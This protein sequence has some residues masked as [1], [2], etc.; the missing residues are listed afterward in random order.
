ML[1]VLTNPIPVFEFF[2]DPGCYEV[3]VGVF[4]RFVIQTV[5][6]VQFAYFEGR[7]NAI[8][9]GLATDQNGDFMFTVPPSDARMWLRV[10]TTAMSFSAATVSGIDQGTTQRLAACVPFVMEIKNDPSGTQTQAA[11]H[12]GNLSLQRGYVFQGIVLDADGNPLSDVRS[13]SSGEYGPHSGPSTISQKDGRFEFAAR[14]A[15]EFTIHPDARLRNDAGKVISEDVQAV[16]V[17]QAVKS[18]KERVTELVIRAVPHTELNFNWLDKRS[19][20]SQPVAYYGGFR[21][22]GYVTAGGSR[23]YWTTRATLAPNSE[24]KLLRAKV[25]VALENA[26]L[27]L[28][29]DSK[30]SAGYSDSAGNTSGPGVIQ[31]GDVTQELKRT[32]I[33]N[34]PSR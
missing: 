15:G 17:R 13:T 7:W 25:P 8:L 20:T 3:R 11:L 27:L 10:G 34:D 18:T 6:C 2:H 16:F 32:I 21:I 1:Q 19:D 31:L 12:L 26:E 30:V 24:R 29:F 22:R 4:D 23:H 14:G 28:T 5:A 33:G 9:E